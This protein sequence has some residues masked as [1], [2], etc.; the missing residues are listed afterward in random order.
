MDQLTSIESSHIQL[1]EDPRCRS[2]DSLDIEKAKDVAH[3]EDDNADKRI[4]VVKFAAKVVAALL[5]NAYIVYSIYYHKSNGLTLDWCGGLGFLL[6][7]T[8]FVYMFLIYVHVVTPLINKLGCNIRPPDALVRLL[9]YRYSQLAIVLLALL[10]IIIFLIVD[11][12][13]D[14]YREALSNHI[15]SNNN[16]LMF[17][18]L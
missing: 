16:H 1:E 3:D 14:R 4:R 10:A 8:G 7:L 6:I 12:Q 15:Y 2:L 5:Y 18:Q 17:K 9:N 13:K 11:T